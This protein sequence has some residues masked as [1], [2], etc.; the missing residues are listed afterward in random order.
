MRVRA[1]TGLKHTL[2]VCMLL[3]LLGLAGCSRP[4]PDDAIAAAIHEMA[5][6]LGNRQAS[7]IR[8]R[9]AE[10]FEL[11][12]YEGRT[13]MNRDETRRTLAG[14]LLRYPDIRVVITQVSVVPDGV[15]EDLA[16]ARFNALV[17]GGQGGLL[18]EQGQLFRVHS[19]W[20]YLDGDWRVIRASAARPLESTS[21]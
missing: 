5:D 3:S 16:E 17:T 6:A 15:R 7:V 14:L 18:P 19:D 2:S 11:L 20:Q 1:R 21:H 13:R 10:D 12:Q 4:A 8:N 9:L